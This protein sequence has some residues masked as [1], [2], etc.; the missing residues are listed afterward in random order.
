MVAKDYLLTGP[1]FTVNG[2]EDE[3]TVTFNNPRELQQLVVAHA[4]FTF[5]LG[6]LPPPQLSLR[7]TALTENTSRRQ[8]ELTKAGAEQTTDILGHVALVHSVATGT[9]HFQLQRPF[10]VNWGNF[11]HKV[12]SIDFFITD[13][14]G[15][16][17]NF[18][19]E[20]T[21]SIYRY[22]FAG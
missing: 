4:N 21:D 2:D 13:H 6:G 18:L 5:D 15:A 1:S 10:H 9:G 16:R 12:P 3:L 17:V 11:R 7:S 22:N 8:R 20:V 14:T 19:M